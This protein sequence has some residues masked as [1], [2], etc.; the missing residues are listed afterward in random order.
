MRQAISLL[1]L[2]IA[3]IGV[4]GAQGAA[5]KHKAALLIEAREYDWCHYDCFPFDRP[6]LFFC[7]NV[8]GAILIGSRAADWRWMYDSEQMVSF[9]GK[10]VSLRHND[11]SIWIIRT[12]GKEMQLAQD[13]SND[14]S[15]I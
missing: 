9:V 12:D 7:L 2:L 3:G 15:A 4:L 5:H 1:G 11:R 13:Y 6:A 14:L 8:D 10:S